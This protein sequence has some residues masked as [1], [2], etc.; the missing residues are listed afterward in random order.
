MK[1][2]VVGSGYVG[3]TIAAAL[4]DE[5]HQVTAVDIDPDKVAQINAGE[6]PIEEPGVPELIEQHSGSRLEAATDYDDI[7]D[8]ELTII[9]VGTPSNDDGSL[10]PSY[11]EAAAESIGE[12]VDGDHVVVIKSTVV[13]GI[14]NER[15]GPLVGGATLASNPEFQREGSALSDFRNPDKVV[16]GADENAESVYDRLETLYAPIIDDADPAVVRTGLDEAMLIKYANNAFLASKVSVVN[17]LANVCKS[18]DI[19]AYEVMEAVGLDDR[20]SSQFMRSGLGW[21][22][23]CF[24][25]DVDALRAFAR[26][27]DYEPE[28][29]DAVVDTNDRQARRAV[30][31]LARHVELE[32][33]RIAVLGLAFKPET[34][35]IRNSRA[36]D[37][38]EHLTERGADIVAYDPEAME[39]AREVPDVHVEFA[40]SANDAI[41]D[42]TGVLIATDWNEFHGLDASGKIVVDGRRL[43]IENAAV[44]EGLCW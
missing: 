12:V 22:G 8:T 7:T 30:E 2:S 43:D 17:E 41:E 18:T 26:E 31:L 36:L 23:S 28:L 24:P 15:L 3:T 40:D 33:A 37:V 27:N 13:P 11:L 29:L 14:L 10:D 25:K 32:D 9:A 19:D 35:D 20:I 16:F 34:D 1:I 44:Y 21:G 39:N 42:A 38:I 6:S 4:A 5:G